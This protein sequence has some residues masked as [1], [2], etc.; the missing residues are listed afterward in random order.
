MS[1]GQVVVGPPGAGKTT[2]C[3]A[4]RQHLEGIWDDDRRAGVKRA[5]LA[6]ELSYAEET[7]ARVSAGLD[8]YAAAL[9]TMLEQLTIVMKEIAAGIP[10]AFAIPSPTA[11]A[12]TV[13]ET[14]LEF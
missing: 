6:T 2:Y 7:L 9:L 13:A 8:R 10:Q 5:L 14:A 11:K 12:K 1:F 3:L 4:M